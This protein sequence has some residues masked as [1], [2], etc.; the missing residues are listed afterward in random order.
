MTIRVSG[1]GNKTGTRFHRVIH[2]H[3]CL[4]ILF[5]VV[6][7]E[8]WVDQD[9]LLG[10]AVLVPL[11]ISFIF[12]FDRSFDVTPRKS[13]RIRFWLSL[14]PKI[15]L[16]NNEMIRKRVDRAKWMY[17]QRDSISPSD[18]DWFHFSFKSL[19]RT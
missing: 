2:H 10:K 16:I 8:S 11:S 9:S 18:N 4:L 3:F 1:E 17:F 12:T 19:Q 5:T 7:F 13:A 14:L 15:I 6:F